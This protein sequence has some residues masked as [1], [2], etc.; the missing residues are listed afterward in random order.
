[1]SISR[2]RCAPLRC[3]GSS[4]TLSGLKSRWT[5]PRR[6]SRCAQ[7]SSARRLPARV[8]PVAS[9]SAAA[10]VCGGVAAAI[11]S[12]RLVASPPS[13]PM[14]SH[15]SHRLPCACSSPR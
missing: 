12:A 11:R 8:S 14:R 2:S 13:A 4:S 15:T 10:A 3:A 1:M 9:S 6:C 5:K 7:S